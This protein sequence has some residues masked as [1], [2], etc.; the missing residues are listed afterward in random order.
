MSLAS[1]ASVFLAP[2]A[3]DLA[4]KTKTH[5]PLLAEILGGS[6]GL[7][8]GAFVGPWAREPT[9]LTHLLILVMFAS[10][11]GT[12]VACWANRAL[13]ENI[14]HFAP[15]AEDRAAKNKPQ[16]PL[17]AKLVGGSAELW[18]ARVCRA[19]VTQDLP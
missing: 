14:R 7:L 8:R 10:A 1:V 2:S 4:A 19:N 11:A 3:Q 15:S 5:V 16:V 18:C 17:R 12:S 13:G 6:T 9:N